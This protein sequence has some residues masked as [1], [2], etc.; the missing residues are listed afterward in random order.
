MTFFFFLPSIL[1]SGFMFPFRGMPGWAQVI[2]EAIPLTHY[3]RVVRGVMLK[4]GGLRRGRRTTSGRSPCSGWRWRRSRWSATGGRSTEV[5]GENA[6]AL[7][8]PRRAPLRS[9]RGRR[10]GSSA[11][12]ISTATTASPVAR[13][14]QMPTPARSVAKAEHDAERQADRP[15]SRCRQRSSARACRRGR[16]A[17]RWRRTWA[18]VDELEQAGEDEDRRRRGR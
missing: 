1:L 5:T 13:P 9:G 3:L 2:G 11:T 4:G 7:R 12:V 15:N 8:P 6:F 17:F 18:A 14:I 10:G 16:A